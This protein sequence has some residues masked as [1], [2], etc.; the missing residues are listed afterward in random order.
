MSWYKENQLITMGKDWN[1]FAMTYPGTP[2]RNIVVMKLG[3][4]TKEEI[5]KIM[6]MNFYNKVIDPDDLIMFPEL[7]KEKNRP[8]FADFEKKVI[9]E[10]DIFNIGK[11]EKKSDNKKKP[12]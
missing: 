2:W 9:K 12:L 1:R 5:Q 10:S 8:I 3:D 6:D 4:P 11:T 7:T